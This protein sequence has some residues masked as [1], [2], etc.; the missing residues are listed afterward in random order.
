MT[1][2]VR[3]AELHPEE[4]DARLSDAPIAYLPL[5]TLEW[6]GEHLPYGTDG[7]ISGDFF[8]RLA[9]RVGGIVLPT[10]FLGP[11]LAETVD[12]ETFYGM[13]V[14]GFRGEE[15]QRL[16]GSAY[17]VDDGAFEAILDA[18]LAQ[19]DRAGFEMVV[20]HGHGPST[21]FVEDHQDELTESYGIQLLT[22]RQSD[23]E[24]GLQV[25]H[26][27]ANETSL[28]Q[29]LHADLVDTDRLSDGEWPVGVDGED[30]R[31]HASPERGESIVDK[32]L[33]R[34]VDVLAET[35]ANE[36]DDSG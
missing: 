2:T 32:E 24:E 16:P 20:A 19:L 7:L 9:E 12:G 3:Y 13:D 34:M 8:D 14:Y 35:L 17:W 18:T 23:D 15:P 31:E 29:A 11:D 22:C 26:A 30:P 10:L 27:A 36:C 1:N 28:M 33:D 6:H 21:T 25:D 5:G 4:F